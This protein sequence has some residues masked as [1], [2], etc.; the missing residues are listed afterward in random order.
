MSKFISN[1]L[2]FIT[3]SLA[4]IGCYHPDIQQ[5]NDFIPLKN[6]I[7]LGMSKSEI[8]EILGPSM[9]QKT[10]SDS[11]SDSLVYVYTNY[12]TGSRNLTKQS[13]TLYFKNG[14]LIKIA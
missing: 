9:L 2:L 13:M 10:F 12:A 1:S 3:L 14:R 7:K 5:G 6:E 4:L 8:I 11:N